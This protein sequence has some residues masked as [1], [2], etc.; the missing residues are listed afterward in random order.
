MTDA[1]AEPASLP[2]RSRAEKIIALCGLAYLGAA[3]VDVS[4]HSGQAAQVCAAKRA[5]FAA[6]AKG[7]GDTRVSI[8]MSTREAGYTLP[9][10][11]T[12]CELNPK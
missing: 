7:L 11:Q 2:H 3:L 10:I 12:T 9:F 8:K 4:L 1:T 5:E 6:A